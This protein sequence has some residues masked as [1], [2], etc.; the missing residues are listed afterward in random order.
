[1]DALQLVYVRRSG[2]ALEASLS[3]LEFTDDGTGMLDLGLAGTVEGL[4]VKIAGRLG[5]FTGLI[6]AASVEHDLEGHLGE[7][8]FASAGRIADLAT[9]S[10]ADLN[11]R[12]S[13]QDPTVVTDAFDLPSLPS[14]AFQVDLGVK[15]AAGGSHLELDA[16]A[17]EITSQISGT[18][19]SLTKPAALDVTVH[20]SGPDVATVGE[21]S[22]IEGLPAQ[23]FSVSG[24][25]QWAGFPLTCDNVAVRVG[26]NSLSA[27]GVV[28]EPP[29]MLG[30]DFTFDGGGPDIA[31]IAALAG[32]RLPRDSY[33]VAG[34][35]VR[36]EEGVG[37]QGIEATVGR[38]TLKIDGVVGDPPDYSGTDL[39]IKGSGPKLAHFQEL[40]GTALPSESF[41]IEGRLV[42]GD[43][44]VTLEAVRARL[45]DNT[46]ELGGQ[47]VTEAGFAGTDLQLKVAGPDAAR[48][49]AMAEISDVPAEPFSI[50]GRLRVLEKGYRVKTSRTQPRSPASRVC[51]MIR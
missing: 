8:E 49:A 46:L 50:E 42:E 19:D 6:N 4:P 43:R 39:T 31:S 23:P 7:N 26:D 37:V 24:R 21:L 45:G 28:G 9:L 18:L 30:T 25:V 51:P 12:V 22:G 34:R 20:F 17:G 1:V 10:G 2:Q 14:G 3:N 27:N 35:L 33:S 47:I 16:S 15:P 32:V 41:A 5:T 38:T 13:G 40:A 11:F 29:L 48:L 44:A 36:F